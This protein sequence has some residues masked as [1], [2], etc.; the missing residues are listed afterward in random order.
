MINMTSLTN[1][2]AWV[3]RPWARVLALTGVGTVALG[4]AVT[5]SAT[6]M[7][8]A[9]VAQQCA[10]V[11]LQGCE[12]LS[13]GVLLYL[14]DKKV[15]GRAK[16]LEGAAKNAPDD[17]RKYAVALRALQATVPGLGQ[18]TQPLNEVTDI[19][20][21]ANGGKPAVS[22]AS[23]SDVQNVTNPYNAPRPEP[24]ERDARLL[25]ADTDL[26]RMSHGTLSAP[27]ESFPWCTQAFGVTARCVLVQR[28]TL[29]LT[30]LLSVGPDCEGQFMAVMRGGM[31]QLSFEGPFQFHG[32]R[33]IIPST[34]ALVLGQRQ[35]LPVPSSPDAK[36]SPTK[37]GPT[38]SRTCGYYYSGYKP[39][40]TPVEG[41]EA[42]SKSTAAPLEVE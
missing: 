25:T 38:G 2:W 31:V 6:V 28:G 34:D 15:E 29:V 22:A 37:A 13:E 41:A 42:T 17:V 10:Q 30:D 12:E 14:S 40:E 7:L 23:P 11:P 21:Q 26:N 39:Y 9:P 18:L 27:S 1:G 16:I 24:A 8:K 4:C 19:L 32:A 20:L 35:E 3:G 36:K 5:G 33:I